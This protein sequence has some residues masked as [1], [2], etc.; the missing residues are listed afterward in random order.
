MSRTARNI[1]GRWSSAIEGGTI[2]GL[3][4]NGEYVVMQDEYRRTYVPN[5]NVQRLRDAVWDH[6][7]YKLQSLL[8]R[9]LY[10]RYTYLLAQTVQCAVDVAGETECL[11]V[12]RCGPRTRA[13]IWTPPK[14]AGRLRCSRCS[15]RHARCSLFSFLLHHHLHRRMTIPAPRP[16]L[17]P[18]LAGQHCAPPQQ[19]N[20]AIYTVESRDGD[21]FGPRAVS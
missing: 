8:R 15:S 13:G 1:C 17:I 18:E 12:A 3:R 21:R 9:M 16:P 6:R 7:R 20:D 10:L 4:R 14:S 2:R 11:S 19:T 5:L